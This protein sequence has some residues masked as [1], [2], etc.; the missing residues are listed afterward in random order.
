MLTITLNTH[1]PA[2]LYAIYPTTFKTRSIKIN[3]IC[4]ATSQFNNTR[5]P[6]ILNIT[7]TF[8]H[9]NCQA[10]TSTTQFSE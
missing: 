9:S 10:A 3:Y 6:I 5:Y 8:T 4:K 2:T 1:E 7:P